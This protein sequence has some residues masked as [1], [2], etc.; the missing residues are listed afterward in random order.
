M[1]VAP[2]RRIFLAKAKF[3]IV[4]D[5]DLR[6]FWRAQP[7]FNPGVPPVNMHFRI[8]RLEE[9]VIVREKAA[10]TVIPTSKLSV[11]SLDVAEI[12]LRQLD[13]YIVIVQIPEGVTIER[14]EDVFAHGSLDV[15]ILDTAVRLT[16]R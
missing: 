16:A 11:A 2:Y 10:V 13:C 14:K 1:C 8:W 12:R 5:G 15:Q 4:T 6:P 3:M 7:Q 9:D